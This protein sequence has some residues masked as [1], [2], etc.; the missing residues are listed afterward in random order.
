MASR[1]PVQLNSLYRCTFEPAWAVPFTLG[2]L[3]LA[4]ELGSVSVICGGA[5]ACESSTYGRAVEHAEALPAA[6]IAVARNRVVVLS[7]TEAVRPGEAN[8]AAEPEAT[9]VPVQPAVV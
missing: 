4:G 7:A 9:G 1:T 5:G 8:W 2:A 6:S 3:L